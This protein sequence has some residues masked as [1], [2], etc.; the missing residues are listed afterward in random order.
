M[1]NFTEIECPLCQSKNIL[2][3]FKDDDRLKECQDCRIVFTYPLPEFLSNAYGEDYYR[4]WYEKQFSQRVILWKKRLKIVKKFC[5]SGR[6]LDVGTGDGLFLKTASSSNFEIYG[7]EVFPAA[8]K[9][10]K[11]LYGLDIYLTEIEN[12]DFEKDYFDVITLWHVIEHVKAPLQIFEAVHNLLRPGGVII[13]A[14]PNLDKHLSRFLYRVLHRKPF[15]FYSPKG[16]QHLFHFTEDTL[17]RMINRA[18][19]QTLSKGADFASVRR[20]FKIIEY[21]AFILSIL[22]RRNWNENIL[23]V[24]QK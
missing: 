5:P 12:S 9:A 14:T 7:T 1:T 21:A 11:D 19:F 23:I 2:N 4:P 24:G 6:L 8:V 16:E 15:P 22:L 20:K 13:V 10:A 18:G 17:E 3:Y